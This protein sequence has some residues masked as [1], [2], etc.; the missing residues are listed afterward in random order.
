MRDQ[1]KYSQNTSRL[2][3]AKVELT[4][5]MVA[6][7]KLSKA[8]YRNELITYVA[9]NISSDLNGLNF[10]QKTLMIMYQK[11]FMDVFLHECLSVQNQA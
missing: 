10:F 3:E 1:V 2:I 11:K 4:N 7:I 6:Y 8:T 5:Y 9:K